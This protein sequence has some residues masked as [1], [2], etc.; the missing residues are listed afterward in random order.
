M[1][2][3]VLDDV[4]LLRESFNAIAEIVDEGT[5]NIKKDGISLVCPDRAVIAVVDFLILPTAFESYT[6]D[7]DTEVGLNILKILQF[8]KKAKPDDKLILSL[9]ENEDRFELTLEGKTTRQFAI[10]IISVA[11]QEMQDLSR[12]KFENSA[13]LDP[14][15]LKEGIENGALISDGISIKLSKDSLVLRSEGDSSYTQIKIDAG[16]PQL[17]SINCKEEVIARYSIEYL[18]KML[19]A[20]RLSENVKIEF[21]K[22]YPLH[23]EYVI[24]D[25]A[26]LGFILA[27][28]IE[29]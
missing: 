22:D 5:F 25:R 7:K 29:E 21:N 2:K 4:G 24:K 27:P 18:S 11:K 15:I 9:D 19:K 3:A 10:P 20:S 17:Y 1:F 12:F 8:I 26:K 14:S 6:C 13:E 23:L 28:R 16:N